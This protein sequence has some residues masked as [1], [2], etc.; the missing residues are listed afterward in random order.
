MIADR[1]GIVLP[2]RCRPQ[3]LRFAQDDGSGHSTGKRRF[4][5]CVPAKAAIGRLEH[6]SVRGLTLRYPDSGRGI[7]D[8]SFEL[9][10]GTLTVITGRV[11]SGKTTLLRALLGLLEPQ[12]GEV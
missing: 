5:K 9:A 8:V 11:G 7:E 10:R 3:I 4:G 12:A 2:N 1:H 6:L